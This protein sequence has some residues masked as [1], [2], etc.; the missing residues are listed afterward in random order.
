MHE[1]NLEEV[2]IDINKNKIDVNASA[3]PQTESN[4]PTIK[5]LYQKQKHRFF[6]KCPI[7]I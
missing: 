2:A 5:V 6:D 4:Y 7:E 3:P 1:L